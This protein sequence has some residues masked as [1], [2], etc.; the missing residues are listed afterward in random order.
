ME[1][2]CCVGKKILMTRHLY[3]TSVCLRRDNITIF[4]KFKTELKINIKIKLSHFD[5]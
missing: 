5:M 1:D 3:I 2:P 4:V